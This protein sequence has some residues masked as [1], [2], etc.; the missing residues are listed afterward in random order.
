MWVRG[1]GVRGCRER[2]CRVRG[3]GVRARPVWPICGLCAVEVRG[4]GTKLEGRSGDRHDLN[5]A[6]RDVLDVGRARATRLD[7]VSA[8]DLRDLTMRGCACARVC[9]HTPR[10]ARLPE[11]RCCV[12]RQ[13]L[14]AGTGGGR[15]RVR[16]RRVNFAFS[17]VAFLAVSELAP[18]TGRSGSGCAVSRSPPCCAKP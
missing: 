9:V 15:E 2:G 6:L 1:C 13:H 12:R 4:R 17:T 10:A 8:V 14:A 16:R 11:S 5:G 18:P 7:S 3:C